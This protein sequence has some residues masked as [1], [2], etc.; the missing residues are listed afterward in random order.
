MT[1]A[2]IR[3]IVVV[4]LMAVT[5]GATA[6]LKPTRHLADEMPKLQL[7]TLF[8]KTFGDWRVDD[9][10]PVQL[11]SPDSEALLKKLYN[12][13]LSRTYVGPEGRRVMLSVAYGGDQ[14][15]ATRAHR[16]EVCYPAQG[17]QM[18]ASS[19]NTLQLNGETLKV[20]RLV[21]QL[22]G[23]YEPITYWIVVG[24]QVTATGVEQKLAQ[25]RYGSQGLVPDGMLVRVSSIDR[26][27]QAAFNLHGQFV[28]DLARAMQGDQRGRVFGTR[29]A[30]DGK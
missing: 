4:L 5:L 15:D 30:P 8:P 23:R 29:V 26:D 21:A 17:F 7:D 6:A 22:G 28:A 20:R 12:Q 27:D 16:P 18:L 3:A 24:E 10:Q 19:Q 1:A 14:S 13:T 11:V 2:R 25:L 9:T